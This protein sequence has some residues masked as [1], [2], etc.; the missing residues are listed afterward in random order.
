MLAWCRVGPGA[1]SQ[2][3]FALVEVLLEPEPFGLGHGAV[4]IGGPC[5]AA[6]VEVGLVV[7]DEIFVEHRD[8]PASSLKIQVS[9]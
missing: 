5:P 1:S 6:A 9:E 4:L 8:I 3:D 2:L 7:A